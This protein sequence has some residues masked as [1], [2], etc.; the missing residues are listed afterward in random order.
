MADSLSAT[1]ANPTIPG[2][3][4]KALDAHWGGMRDHSDQYPSFTREQ[5]AERA[6]ALV[7]SPVGSNIDGYKA[8]NGAIVRYDKVTNDFVKA[9]NTGVATMYKPEDGE[10]YFSRRMLKEGGIQTD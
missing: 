4:Q 6:R 2:M 3:T 9:F 7:R 10:A 1:G 8:V 5:Y